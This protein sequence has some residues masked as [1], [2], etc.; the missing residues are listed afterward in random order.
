MFFQGFM[1]DIKVFTWNVWHGEEL[2]IWG[3]LTMCCGR[4][5][6]ESQRG[7]RENNFTYFM[8]S[9]RA[10][11]DSAFQSFGARRSSTGIGAA[12]TAP[13][14]HLITLLSLTHIVAIVV[15]FEPNRCF[16]SRANRSSG[17]VA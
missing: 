6:L 14:P 5:I 9:R 11:R 13:S 1:K 16:D 10:L 17:P 4:K 15:H 8:H 7:Q 12:W 2:F 3:R